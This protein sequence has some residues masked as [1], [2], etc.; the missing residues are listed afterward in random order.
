VLLRGR[1]SRGTRLAEIGSGLFG[2]FIL[3][4]ILTDGQVIASIPTLDPLCKIGVGVAL[5]IVLS[6]TGL[7]CY[8]LITQR[9]NNNNKPGMELAAI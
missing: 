8:R 6:N 5:V 9:W 4:R 3:V 1:W 2:V 7:N